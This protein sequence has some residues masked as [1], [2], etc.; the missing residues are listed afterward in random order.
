M[1]GPVP[2]AVEVCPNCGSFWAYRERS[3]WERGVTTTFYRCDGCG[4]E[5]T[6]K[7]RQ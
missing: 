3:V 4:H 7:R 5:W 6:G 1:R 2:Q